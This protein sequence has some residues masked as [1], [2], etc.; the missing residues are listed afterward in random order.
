MQKILYEE[1]GTF[2]PFHV[3]QVVVTSARVSGLE[4]VFDDGVRYH[5]VQVSD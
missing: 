2:I 5:L 1:G 3:N 4:P